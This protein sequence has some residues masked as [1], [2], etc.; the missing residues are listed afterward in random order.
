MKIKQWIIYLIVLTMA[1]GLFA[2]CSPKANENNVDNYPETD[3]VGY[4]M[5]GAGGG[6]DNVARALT[7]LVEK[8]LGKRDRKSVV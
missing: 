1:T 4:I 5:W 3:L 8:K 6:T 2:G 7:P